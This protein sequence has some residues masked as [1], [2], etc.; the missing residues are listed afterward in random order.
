MLG[1]EDP[2]P[3]CLREEKK[4]YNSDELSTLSVTLVM[5]GYHSVDIKKIV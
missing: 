4:Y 1:T 3:L 5:I 2:N